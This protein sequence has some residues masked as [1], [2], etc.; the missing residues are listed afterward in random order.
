MLSSL[1][2]AK[3]AVSRTKPSLVTSLLRPQSSAGTKARG[4]LTLPRRQLATSTLSPTRISFAR[5]ST[6]TTVQLRRFTST[7][8]RTEDQGHGEQETI[9]FAD[10]TRPDLF[11]HLVP[12]PQ[13]LTALA[14]P[15]FAV[16]ILP[17][18]P[19]TPDSHTIMGWLPAEAG[20]DAGLN[21]FRENPNFRELLQEA[22]AKGLAEGVD[23][24]QINGAKQIGQGWMHI[25]DDRNIP[26]LGRIG[27]P[28]DILGTVLVEDGEMLPQTYSPMPSYRLCT[29]DGVTQLTDG[30]AKKLE[31]VLEERAR[32]EAKAMA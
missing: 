17:A 1:R 27:D 7:P 3:P 14:G 16:S 31:E 6:F 25:H 10:P 30:L 4:I 9:S 2:I 29:A 15:V 32:V 22:I 18:P 12:V 11:Y 20:E 28:D 19:P 13:S 8:S 24:I 21:D 26:A 5:Q 23:D